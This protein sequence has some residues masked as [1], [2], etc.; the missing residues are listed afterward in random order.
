[1]NPFMSFPI[2]VTRLSDVTLQY[3]EEAV[4]TG[5]PV[6][7]YGVI[8]VVV[9][10]IAG[11]LYA[12]ANQTPTIL[13]TPLGLLHELCKAHRIT[14][15]GRVLLEKI[16]SEVSLKHPAGLF[17]AVEAFDDV[18]KRAAETME[19]T[20]NQKSTLSMLRRKMFA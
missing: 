12:K 15:R 18:V 14:G 20:A 1:M 10:A 7:V 17:T 6:W 16:A 19:Y 3:Q 9:L 4:N 5:I 2:A 8:A 11:I 13:N